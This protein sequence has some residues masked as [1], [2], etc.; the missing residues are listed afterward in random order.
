MRIQNTPKI[1]TKHC[2][3]LDY[4]KLG[5]TRGCCPYC[6]DDWNDGYDDPIEIC[7]GDYLALVCCDISEQIKAHHDCDG[8]C[9]RRTTS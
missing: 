1:N 2:D 4:E 9:Y 3:Q 5:L 6:H 7:M 8:D